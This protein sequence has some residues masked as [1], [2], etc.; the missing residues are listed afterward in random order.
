MTL[1]GELR[2]GQIGMARILRTGGAHQISKKNKVC[3]PPGNE[4]LGS[5]DNNFMWLMAALL[6][7]A[8]GSPLDT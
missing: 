1:S 8:E 7:P 6:A 2:S 5:A 3:E 4:K